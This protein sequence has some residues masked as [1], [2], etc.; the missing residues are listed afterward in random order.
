MAVGS[1]VRLPSH[2]VASAAEAGLRFRHRV[3]RK[4]PIGTH[5]PARIRSATGSRTCREN[6][7][8]SQ[9]RER[10]TIVNYP[11]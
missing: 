11:L 8:C 4:G 5:G 9:Q 10:Q 6:P 7:D 3:R 1:Q 2:G